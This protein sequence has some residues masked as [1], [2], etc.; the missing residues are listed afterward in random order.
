MIWFEKQLINDAKS[1]IG[2]D[3]NLYGSNLAQSIHKRLSLTKGVSAYIESELLSNGAID[4]NNLSDF[5]AGI[6]ESTTGILDIAIAPNGIMEYVYPYEPN[7]SVIGYEPAK[8]ERESVRSDVERAIES[9]KIIMSLPI[10]LIQGGQGLIARQA[11]FVEDQYWG[12]TSLVVEVSFIF[13]DAGIKNTNNFVSLSIKDQSGNIFYGDE[14]IFAG[15]PIVVEIPLPEGKWEL[16]GTPKGGWE[17]MYASTLRNYYYLGGSVVGLLTLIIYLGITRQAQLL[18]LVDKKTRQ[19]K[20][21]NDELLLDMIIRKQAEN[22]YLKLFT[23]SR[24]GYTISNKSGEILS[25]NPAF[26]NMLGYT[27]EEI[28]GKYWQEITPKKW[29]DIESGSI[30]D[31]FKSHGYSDLYEKEYIHKDG[32][33]IPVEVQ[34]FLIDEV[35]NFEDSTSAAFVRDISE[36]IKSER[37]LQESEERLLTLTQATFE[38]IVITNNN[39]ITDVNEQFAKMFGYTQKELI[40]ANTENLVHNDDTKLLRKFVSD[41]TVD[42]YQ[43]RGK[44]K[45]GTIISIENRPRATNINGKKVRITTTRDITIQ[46]EAE[47]SLKYLAT[48]DALTK[49]PNRNLL[50]DRIH[51]AISMAKRNKNYFAIVFV[52]LDNFKSVNDAFGHERGDWILQQ[53]SNRIQSC[54]RKSDTAARFGGDEFVLLFENLNH[55]NEIINTI[56]KIKN[57][58]SESFTIEQVEVSITISIGI[59]IYP[60]DGKDSDVLIQNADRAMYNIKESGKG[61]FQFFSPDMNTESLKQLRIRNELRNSIPNNQFVLHYQPQIDINTMNIVGVEALVRWQHPEEG[62]IYPDKF[63]DHVEGSGLGPVLGKWVLKTAISQLEKWVESGHHP[64]RLSVN[65]SASQIKNRE[66]AEYINEIFLNSFLSP[67]VLEL[68]IT[69]NIVFQDLKSA[70]PMLKD[71]K[72]IG[73]RIA[74]DD[75]GTGYSTLSHLSMFPI[76]T[77]KIDRYFSEQAIISIGDAAVVDGIITIAKNL[78]LDIVVEGVENVTQLEFFKKLQCN[79]IQ[80]Y[81]FHKPLPADEIDRLLG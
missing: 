4:P 36:K 24:D 81:Y 64:I 79:L 57:S 11:I 67:E 55:P 38:G 7:K 19:L 63:I 43:I 51:H 66:M 48:H 5:S 40:G 70:L 42:F 62:L 52:D 77:L 61:N 15:S 73:V 25:S 34:F 37:A 8:D 20:E 31:K 41:S 46:T 54:M 58:I 45:D 74:I 13:E 76:N 65:V 50:N 1:Q 75:F 28:S 59:S 68:E 39:L 21:K 10:E 71:L 6:Y 16:A 47:K 33:L 3:I 2:I 27:T 9:R 30:V 23:L 18:K 32:S 80:G 60:I 56:E 14:E 26:A 49:L 35:E 78:G 17:S 53:L 22:D 69:E 12:L 44:K 29:I 72:S